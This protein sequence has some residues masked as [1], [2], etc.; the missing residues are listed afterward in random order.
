MQPSPQ[1]MT[2]EIQRIAWDA[3]LTTGDRFIDEQHTFLIDLVNDLAD[4]IADGRAHEDLGSTLPM[5]QTYVEWHFEWEENCMARARCPMAAINERAH[6]KFVEM[7]LAFKDEYYTKGGSEEL[8]ARM[9]RN[10]TGWLVGHIVKVDT[11][12]LHC[13]EDGKVH[14]PAVAQPQVEASL[15][16]PFA[17]VA[18]AAAEPARPEIAAPTVSTP[19][20]ARMPAPPVPGARDLGSVLSQAGV[21]SASLPPVAPSASH[22][23]SPPPRAAVPPMPPMAAPARPAQPPVAP[24]ASTQ[25]PPQPSLRLDDS[26]PLDAIPRDAMEMLQALVR[27]SKAKAAAAQAGD[28]SVR[29]PAPPADQQPPAQGKPLWKS[30]YS[31]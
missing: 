15:L 24:V 11:A 20:A 7:F 5:L 10:L 13:E 29:Q 3:S 28:Q 6:V 14:D 17:A 21:P 26:I 23:V 22:P 8:A 25:P 27:A 1:R 16:D 19:A 31:E 2:G 30:I 12:L 4:M 9:Y 18:P